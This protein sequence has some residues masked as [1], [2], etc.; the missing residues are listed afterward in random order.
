MINS[1]V[2][3]G[4]VTAAA[5]GAVIGLLVAPEDGKKIRKK[6]KKSANDWAS[7]MID[8]L[9]KGKSKVL[10]AAEQVKTKGEKYKEEALATTEDAIDTAQKAVNKA[11]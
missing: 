6:I 8:A 1:K 7:D 3:W 5:A 9:E 10:D 11:R 4:I 2:F